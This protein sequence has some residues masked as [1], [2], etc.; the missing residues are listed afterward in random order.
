MLHGLCCNKISIV[1][2]KNNKLQKKT[3]KNYSQ[4]VPN[5][6]G[7]S[8]KDVFQK[9]ISYKLK[10]KN[11]DEKIPLKSIDTLDTIKLLNMLYRSLKK[12]LD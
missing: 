12:F 9:I 10:P 2:L 6:Y 4:N 8:H 7:V 11:K 1:D 5:G 3:L